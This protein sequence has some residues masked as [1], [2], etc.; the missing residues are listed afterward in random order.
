MMFHN[1]LPSLATTESKPFVCWHHASELSVNQHSPQRKPAQPWTP[2]MNPNKE[3]LLHFLHCSIL[4]SYLPYLKR[5][6]ST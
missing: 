3:A 2:E 4:L 5:S 6:T 1:R